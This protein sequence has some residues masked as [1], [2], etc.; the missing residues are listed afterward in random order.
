LAADWP[1]AV[2]VMVV[3]VPE[4]VVVVVVMVVVKCVSVCVCVWVGGG[5]GGGGR[6]AHGAW[7]KAIVLTALLTSSRA[8]VKK[9]VRDGHH[10]RKGSRQRMRVADVAPVHTCVRAARWRW[11]TLL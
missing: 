7:D 2:I 9:V 11:P 4:V 10:L 1:A 8:V 5:G 6:H 3:L